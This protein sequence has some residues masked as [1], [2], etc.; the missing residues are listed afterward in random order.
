MASNLRSDA[1]VDLATVELD[2]ERFRELAQNKN[3]SAH[4]RIGFPDN[5]REGFE[6]DIFADICSKLPA[7]EHSGKVI[8]DI[9]PGC[10][11][12]P[13][14]LSALCAKNGNRL[15]LVDSAEMLDQLPDEDNVSK[16]VGSFPGNAE[17]IIDAVGQKA[18]AILCYSVLHYMYVDTNMFDVVDAL[19]SL[20]ADG[21]RALVGDIPNASKRRRFFSSPSGRAFH[22]EFM[23]TDED[24]VVGHLEIDRGKINDA[25]IAGLI[26]RSQ[27]AGWN[28]YLMPQAPGLPFANRRDDLI[29]EH[30]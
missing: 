8:V 11:G 25:V 29:I 16:V 24:P 21:G 15:V 18:D 26:A 10:S 12:L 2:Y 5:Y 19:G 20:L 7:L 4:E 30:P 1:S 6:R 9:G 28:A 13:R 23:K 3:L 27:E 22:R 14:L 17:R